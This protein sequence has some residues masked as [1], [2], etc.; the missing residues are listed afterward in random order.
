M[1]R[2]SF[3]TSIILVLFA[4]VAHAQVPL[5]AIHQNLRE[6]IRT[7]FVDLKFYS[8]DHHRLLRTARC[9]ATLTIDT[10]GP[11][12]VQD[13][14]FTFFSVKT[15]EQCKIQEVSA[16]QFFEM[17]SGLP[18]LTDKYWS[19]LTI[20]LDPLSPGGGTVITDTSLRTQ[21]TSSKT[22]VEEYLQTLAGD[23]IQKTR[24]SLENGKLKTFYQEILPA[25]PY[26]GMPLKEM[27]GSFAF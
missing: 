23:P 13:S 25:G 11:D 20:D 1:K 4:S 6:T 14:H 3:L 15:G 22:S 8:F 18:L 7:G 16:P 2:T 24:I 17:L 12:E 27:Q 5:E 26:R 21:I 9:D 10:I 19:N